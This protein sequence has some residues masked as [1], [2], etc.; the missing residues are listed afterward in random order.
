VIVVDAGVLYAAADGRDHDHDAL[1]ALL[2]VRQ[3]AELIVPAT[4]SRSLP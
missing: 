4:R 3:S 2:D 1:V